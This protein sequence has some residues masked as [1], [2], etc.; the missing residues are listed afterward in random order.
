MYDRTDLEWELIIRRKDERIAALERALIRQVQLENAC[1]G[2]RGVWM[3]STTR[4]LDRP[5]C[6]ASGEFRAEKCGCAEEARNAMAA[7]YAAIA[8]ETPKE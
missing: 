3:D 6:G 7:A 5:P 1:M 8:A 2:N 4:P